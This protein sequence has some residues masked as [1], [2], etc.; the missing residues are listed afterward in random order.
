MTDLRAHS[1]NDQGDWHD[2][3]VHLRDVAEK[4]AQYA[5]PF[6]AASL[7]RWGGFLHDV[8][9]ANPEFQEYLQACWKAKQSGAKPPAPG[10]P[11]AIWGAMV[12]YGLKPKF[13]SAWKDLALPVA[14]HHTGLKSPGK[15]EQE[16]KAGQQ[17]SEPAL[18]KPIRA[19]VCEL[20]LPDVIPEL[21][22]PDPF[23]REL[24]IRMVL[25]ALA[26]ADFLDTERH[27]DEGRTAARGRHEPISAL[28]DRLAASQQAFMQGLEAPDAEINVIRREV[29]EACSNRAKDDPG[30][31][32]LTVPTGG[33]KTRSGLAFALEHA[34][35]HGFEN[36]FFAIPYTSI[37]DQTAEVYGD[38]LG[39]ANVL[40]HHSQTMEPPQQR[41]EAQDVLAVRHRLAAENWDVPVVVTTTVQLF[42]SLFSRYPGRVR[43]LH[44]LARSVIVLDE[45]QALPP[46]VLLPT[47]DVLRALVDDYGATVVFS[48]ATQPAFEDVTKLTPMRDVPITEI[49]PQYRD[50]FQ[51]LQRVRYD[52]P[53]LTPT[54]WDDIVDEIVDSDSDRV[55]VILNTRRDAI[56]LVRRLEERSIEN[57]FHLSTLLYGAHR[58]QVLRRVRQRLRSGQP[59]RLISTQ[60][61]EAGVDIDFPVVYRALGPL[62][63]VVQAAGRCNRE[64]RL[65]SRGGRVVVFEPEGGAIPRGPYR[66]GTGL[67]RDHLRHDDPQCLDTQYAYSRRL[68]SEANL[69]EN[70]VQEARGELDYEAT[71]SRYWLIP[72]STVPVFVCK[73]PAAEERLS[74]W[75]ERQ[76]RHAWRRLQPFVVSVYESQVRGL[77][78]SV[79]F[80]TVADQLYVWRGSYHPRLGLPLTLDDPADLV[81]NPSDLTV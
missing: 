48:S 54:A 53:R 12:A 18:W 52:K 14:G 73:S 77:Q 67:A 26:D 1:P 11:H 3:D 47:L 79:Y 38:I 36:V 35:K 80:E 43:K 2:L 25:S 5:T 30:F 62:D 51:A 75:R 24:R 44:R 21:T 13:G 16:L 37:I 56:E 28:A 69:D 8:G 40:V 64:G 61:V 74:Q 29:Y 39:T 4:A 70:G 42:E 6:N 9:K 65:G 81:Y 66:I 17:A 33:G 22:P 63:R 32:R 50:H 68:L 58:R 76:N 59:A 55:L 41:A 57:V 10:P 71:D 49:V 7:T 34:K 23:R 60:V 27:F 46:H 15:L 72:K 45:I 19:T 20:E 31:F 78:R